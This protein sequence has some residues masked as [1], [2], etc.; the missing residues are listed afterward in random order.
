MGISY[1]FYDEMTL[2]DEK[3]K[4]WWIDLPPSQKPK[5]LNYEIKTDEHGETFVV[6]SGTGEGNDIDAFANLIQRFL[7]ECPVEM[8]GLEIN[9]FECEWAILPTPPD[10]DGAF[11][12]GGFLVTAEDIVFVSTRE[13]LDA[14]YESACLARMASIPHLSDVIKT[15]EPE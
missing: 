6:F 14:E 15:K 12:G 1:L 3:A 2:H 8:E 5:V 7:K 4:K 13:Q 11:G 10:F 9:G